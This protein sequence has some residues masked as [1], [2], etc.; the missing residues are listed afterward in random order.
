MPALL[1]TGGGKEE[2]EEEEDAVG[3]MPRACHS[4]AARRGGGVVE[5]RWWREGDGMGATTAKN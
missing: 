5:G 1:L 2:E 4:Q 3:W